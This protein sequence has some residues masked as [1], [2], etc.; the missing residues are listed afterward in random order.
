MKSYLHFLLAFVCPLAF[1]IVF[2]FSLT[3]CG[4]VQSSTRVAT[5]SSVPQACA[6]AFA[7]PNGNTPLDQ[8]IAKLQGKARSTNKDTANL[9]L[10]QLGWRYIEK[11]RLSYDPGY[12][13]LAEACAE[14]LQAKNNQTTP[15]SLLLRGHALHQMHRFK[16]AEPIARELVKTRGLSFDYGLLGDVLMEQGNL[17]E[18]IEAYQ[19][20]MDQKPNMQAYSRAAHIRWLQGD[21]K[22]AVELG[23]MAAR[24]GSPQDKETTA[25]A[26]SR[27]ALYELQQG[28][29]A[30][31]Q[32]TINISFD[33]QADYAPA[34]LVQGKILLAQDKFNEALTPLKRAAELNP[35][36]EYQWNLAEALRATGKQDEAAKIEAQLVA[37]GAADDP[38]TLSLYLATRQEHT[39]TALT[40]AQK[41]IAARADIYTLD[42]LAWA[43]NAAGKTQEATA[44]MKKALAENT[45][46]ARLFYH[47]GVIAMRSGKKVEAHKFFNQSYSSRQMLLPSERDELKRQMAAS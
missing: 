32:A 35:L 47:A 3:G 8:E 27:L 39:E 42:A 1:I 23:R 18:A 44:P 28:E 4:A 12:Y 30:K 33:W 21:L 14:C 26:Y 5:E 43:L 34:L 10:E 29:I 7:A 38:R 2:A 15:E 24:A 13:K 11:A 25:W 46:D 20:M 6:L 9:N 17:K 36:P 45:K 19:K 22:G 41:E 16:D 31:A 37:K 40:L